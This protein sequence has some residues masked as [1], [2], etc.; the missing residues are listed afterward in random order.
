MQI[1]SEYNTAD[2]AVG[3]V[4]TELLALEKSRKIQ[5]LIYDNLCRLRLATLARSERRL[6]Q[7]TRW[8][9]YL[10]APWLVNYL[11]NNFL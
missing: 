6:V 2:K 8:N 5:G 9:E 10:Q 1:S 3:V 7:K 4:I 11:P